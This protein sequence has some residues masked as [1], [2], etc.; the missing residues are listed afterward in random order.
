METQ[1]NTACLCLAMN[2]DQTILIEIQNDR[3][4]SIASRELV[5][6]FVME[7]LAEGNEVLENQKAVIDDLLKRIKGSIH[8]IRLS[9][10]SG[11]VQ[12]KKVPVALGLDDTWLN[13]QMKWEADQMIAAPLDQYVIDHHRLPFQT[14]SGNPVQLMVMIRK[15]LID[16][17]KTMM[18]QCNLKIIDLD[19]DVFSAIR[20]LSANYDVKRLETSVL[21]NIQRYFVCFTF[22]KN[23]EYFLSHRVSFQEPEF[24]SGHLDSSGFARFVLKEL[25]RLMFGH[26][27]GRDMNDL[28]SI[29]LMG[30]HG[31][32]A[33]YY[34]LSDITT[35]PIEIV[36]P[37]RRIHIPAPLLQAKD[38]QKNPEMF[39]SAIGMALKHQPYMAHA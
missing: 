37:F 2:P 15:K 7:T 24:M 25:R 23:G 32:H 11:M 29:F 27:L 14:I 18:R 6:P 20:G 39:V 33:F 1:S 16:M 31:V 17:L 21:I 13:D 19:V 9:I 26:R 8:Q 30:N 10:H 5:Q 28:D 22:L 35:S 4:E 12:I 36:N 3:I 34:A 38:P